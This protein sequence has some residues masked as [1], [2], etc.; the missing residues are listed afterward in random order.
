MMHEKICTICTAFRPNH[1][2][3]GAAL[4]NSLVKSGFQGELLLGVYDSGPS[5]LNE[6][7]LLS[8]AEVGLDIQSYPLESNDHPS[9]VKPKLLLTAFDKNTTARYGFFFDAD[10]VVRAPFAFFLDRVSQGIALV[11]HERKLPSDP[12]PSA[13]VAQ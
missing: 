4:L 7:T 13:I 12:S 3:G 2:A 11:G 1:E 8:C 6:Q 10:I 9:H 5:W